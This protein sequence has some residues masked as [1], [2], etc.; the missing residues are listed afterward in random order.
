MA[1]GRSTSQQLLKT[2]TETAETGMERVLTA[3]EEMPPA[4]YVAAV[5]ASLLAS[6][7]LMLLPR[8]RSRHWSLFVGLWA[9]TILN[10]GLYSRLR[11]A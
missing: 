8:E 10:L 6:A 9:P 11:R 7:A 5:G 2:T 4:T 3:F 1:F